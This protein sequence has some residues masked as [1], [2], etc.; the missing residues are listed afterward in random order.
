MSN[1]QRTWTIN[2]KQT[3]LRFPP[4]RRLLDILRDDLG[5]TG[6][7]ES[8]GEGACGACTVLVNKEPVVSCILPAGQL[9]NGTDI[10]T[11]E[12][13]EKKR[14]GRVIQQ[15]FLECGAVQCGFCIPGMVV[16]AYALLIK[17]PKPSVR[18][19]REALAG[20]LCRCTGYTKIIQA[21]K[22]AATR[23]PQRK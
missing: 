20:N 18:A 6:S 11:I 4:G 10:L 19:I 8:C 3:K 17:N 15:A 12:G 21:V 14:I 13:I 7:K 22:L 23:M 16:A 5:L 1:V 2:G 9:V